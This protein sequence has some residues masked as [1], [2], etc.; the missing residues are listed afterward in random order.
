MVHIRGYGCSSIIN[1]LCLQFELAGHGLKTGIK[2]SMG[3]QWVVE[4]KIERP[5]RVAV[6]RPVRS[7]KQ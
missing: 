1:A 6:K 4:A 3:G 7:W 5:E 2:R